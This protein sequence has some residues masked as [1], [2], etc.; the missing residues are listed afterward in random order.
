MTSIRILL[1]GCARNLLLESVGGTQIQFLFG[2][3][4]HGNGK[5]LQLVDPLLHQYI[6]LQITVPARFLLPPLPGPPAAALARRRPPLSDP[7]IAA[8]AAR[9]PTP[10]SLRPPSLQP[11]PTGISPTALSPA[12]ATRPFSGRPLVD[13]AFPAR[14]SVF[15]GSWQARDHCCK[16]RGGWV[17]KSRQSRER[18]AEDGEE[19]LNR[20]RRTRGGHAGDAARFLFFAWELGRVAWEREASYR[21]IQ[22]QSNTEPRPS[23]SSTEENG[24]DGYGPDGF[25]GHNSMRIQTS[26]LETRI[27]NSK[28]QAQFIAS[29]HSVIE[30]G[31]GSIIVLKC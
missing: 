21:F 6:S 8:A 22:F 14:P 26:E 31:T 20:R 7:L 13:R 24:P 30:F 1:F 23:E 4:H 5:W 28:F 18:R 19:S 10:A 2:C 9:S 29:K 15:V 3:S 27:P 11:P 25:P 16:R 17:G 12:A